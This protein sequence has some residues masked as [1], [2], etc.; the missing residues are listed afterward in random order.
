MG[1]GF[2]LENQSQVSR[3]F[4][5]PDTPQNAIFSS[6]YQT[7][8]CKMTGVTQVLVRTQQKLVKEDHLL[9]ADLHKNER[10][11]S[12]KPLGRYSLC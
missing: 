3:F 12:P 2:I 4:I 8:Q 10:N 7:S 9:L 6:D 11:I 5:S 1:G